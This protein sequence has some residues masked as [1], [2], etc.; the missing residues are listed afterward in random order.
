MESIDSHVKVVA[1][2]CPKFASL[3]ESGNTTG[4]ELQKIAEIYLAPLKHHSVDTLVLACTHYPYIQP[5]LQK[6]MGERVV[7]IDPAEETAQNTKDYLASICMLNENSTAG[8]SQFYFSSDPAKVQKTAANLFD[9][10]NCQFKYF[11]LNKLSS[12]IPV[13]KQKQ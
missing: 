8:L 12:I 11:D 9:T 13:I 10:S 3:I 1:Q 6:I 7:I 2:A 5:L 4:P